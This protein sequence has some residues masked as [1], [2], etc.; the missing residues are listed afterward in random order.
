MLGS[1]DD[2]LGFVSDMAHAAM[3]TSE[4]LTTLMHCAAGVS[5]LEVSINADP[6]A[7]RADDYPGEFLGGTGWGLHLGDISLVQGNL[8]E[9]ARAQSE[10]WLAAQQD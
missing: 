10:A 3:T 8:V 5:Y 4:C 7:P 2:V 9:L 6:S 1:I